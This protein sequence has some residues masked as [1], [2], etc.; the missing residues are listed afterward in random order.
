[1]A[2]VM[3]LGNF[4]SPKCHWFTTKDIS[5]YLPFHFLVLLPSVTSFTAFDLNKALPLHQQPRALSIS[6]E[7][8]SRI[9]VRWM[10]T[11]QA[12]PPPMTLGA[13]WGRGCCLA[14]KSQ[15]RPF[16]YALLV[17]PGGPE[18]SWDPGTFAPGR[19]HVP[20]GAPSPGSG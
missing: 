11:R 12:S 7:E 8:A 1:M 13:P 4:G 2:P 6:R 5:R 20:R 18:I 14:R 9:S 17:V 3:T 15:T 19:S 16:L 10:T